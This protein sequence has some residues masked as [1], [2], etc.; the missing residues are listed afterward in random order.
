MEVE[1]PAPT[2]EQ[3]A[4]SAVA[5]ETDPPA[6]A[7]EQPA[8]QAVAAETGTEMPAQDEVQLNDQAKDSMEFGLRC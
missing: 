6:P 8:A 5:A 1:T 2:A 4:A 3:P 7:A